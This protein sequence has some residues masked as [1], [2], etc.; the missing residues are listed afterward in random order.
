MTAMDALKYESGGSV[1]RAR[2]VPATEF[3][4]LG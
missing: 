4:R 3:T 1:T 2:G